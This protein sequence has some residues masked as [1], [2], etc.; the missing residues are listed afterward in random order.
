MV[1]NHQNIGE[2]YEQ[3]IGGKSV[4]GYLTV[5]GYTAVVAPIV[6]TGGGTD[7]RDLGDPACLAGPRQRPTDNPANVS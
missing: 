4:Q 7:Q 6:P 2:K 3:N 5:A 1:D